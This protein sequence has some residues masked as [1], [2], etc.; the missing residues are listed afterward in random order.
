MTTHD[1]VATEDG[2]VLDALTEEAVAGR[3]EA[4]GEPAW[5]RDRRLEAFKR[6]ADQAWPQ[7]RGEEL[8]R[9]TPFTRFAVDVPLVT[10]ADGAHRQAGPAVASPLLDQTD[11]SGRV[12]MRDGEV[13]MLG[14]ADA[15][16]AGVTITDLAS[17]A[18]LHEDLVREHLGALTADH[19][20]TVAANDAAWTSGVFVYVPPEVELDRPLGIS[21]QATRPGAHLPRILVVVGNHAR[22][23]LFVE[24][25][26][27]DLVE[28]A[29]VD[30][31]AEI[32]VLDGAKL[33][34]VSLQ[35]WKGRVGHLA[36]Q[37]AALHRDAELRHLAVT[38]GGET[39]RMRPEVRLVGPGSRIEPLGV[40]FSDEGQH[41]EHHPFI[42]HVA[43]HATSD[44]LYKGALQGKSRTVFRGHIYVHADAVGSDSNEVNK[45]LVL[46][47]GA[48][49]DSTPFLEIECSE[50]VAGHGSATGQI[51]EDQL[52]YLESRGVRAE[53]ALRLVVFGFFAEVLE[54]IDLPQVRDRTMAHI[55][56][57]VDRADLSAI[58]RRGRGR[59]ARPPRGDE[60]GRQRAGGR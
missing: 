55:A 59:A 16:A 47:E 9:D 2:L 52:F 57:E 28:A 50:V 37:G 41:F 34:L 44:V 27:P 46:T 35:D 24:H 4:A 12:T 39:V 53:D 30:E 23:K 26:S 6:W 7:L 14:C 56:A 45:S 38:I 49:A 19:D 40:Y 17:A 21:V 13:S 60:A 32:V 42:A 33:D 36:V 1:A 5:L 58:A 48:K 11:L 18:K 31:V 20:R 15:E 8:W 43:G 29:T 25:V 51:D 54:R 3:S 22:A 10:A